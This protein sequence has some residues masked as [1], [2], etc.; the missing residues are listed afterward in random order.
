MSQKVVVFLM[1][2]LAL[3]TVGSAQITINQGSIAP[4]GFTFSSYSTSET[5]AA[6]PGPSGANQSWTIPE[7]TFD[8]PAA[9]E[10]FN[11]ASTPL[12]SYFPTATHAQ[13]DVGSGPNG[14]VWSYIRVTADSYSLIGLV[15]LVSGVDT[16][17]FVY[18]PT[19]LLSPL[20]LSY[21]H[22]SWT[23]VSQYT[24][25][26]LGFSF[27]VRDSVITNLDGWGTVNTQFG[28]WQVLRVQRHRF[29]SSGIQGFPPTTV[30]STEYAWVGQNGLPVVSMSSDGWNPNFTSA[31]VAMQ[32]PGTTAVDPVRGPV[33]KQFS[34]EQNYPNPFN[35]TT[36]LPVELTQTGELTVRIYNETGQLVSEQTE[37]LTA[38][39]HQL[40][41]NATNWSSGSYFATVSQNNSSETVKMQLIK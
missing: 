30:E 41:I 36:T 16:F 8:S 24:Y 34:V 39:A 12:G 17:L 4:I 25:D 26:V 31:F 9:Q 37:M 33:A 15:T 38:G 10:I 5:V 3:A 22:G 35:P 2:A 21:P 13:G 40:P 14:G 19:Q 27:V 18:N 29:T 28:N 32:V 6:T 20:P 7:Q 1:L 11:P 23:T